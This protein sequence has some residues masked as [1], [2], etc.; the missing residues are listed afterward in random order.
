MTKSLPIP[1][2][3]RYCRSVSPRS[4]PKPP[5]DMPNQ[6]VP[7]EPS[8][9]ARTSGNASRSFPANQV[10]R[11]S[12]DRYRPVVVPIHISPPRP[13]YNETTGALIVPRSPGD[14]KRSPVLTTSPPPQVPTNRFFS[15]VSR[16]DQTKRFD[17]PL[18]SVN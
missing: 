9:I 12:L 17:T 6:I 15:L 3:F 16:T 4:E 7:S 5:P 13:W 18:V 1:S 10:T 14:P 8:V 11:S 2:C